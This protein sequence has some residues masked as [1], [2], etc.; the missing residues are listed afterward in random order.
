MHG[1]A[2][3]NA[4][5]HLRVGWVSQ[6]SGAAIAAAFG[7]IL[8]GYV[9]LPETAFP[10]RPL[11]ATPPATHDHHQQILL[12]LVAH[13]RGRLL[14]R[15]EALP[16]AI[17]VRVDGIHDPPNYYGV[18]TRW[19]IDCFFGV[20][21][22]FGPSERDDLELVKSITPQQRRLLCA[23]IAQILDR[24]LSEIRDRAAEP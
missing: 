13:V 24:E 11:G 6:I 20:G 2:G 5:R 14:E 12:D 1:V 10:D 18:A 7:W 21:V 15:V 19:Q 23:D 17:A 9:L 3:F 16:G 4:R 22:R 8:H